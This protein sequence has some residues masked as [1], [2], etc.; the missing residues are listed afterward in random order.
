MIKANPKAAPAFEASV[1]AAIR[2]SSSELI[3]GQM[4]DQL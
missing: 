3:Q 4:F 1:A 2:L